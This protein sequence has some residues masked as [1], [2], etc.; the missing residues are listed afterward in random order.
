ME[1]STILL[2][3]L[4]FGEYIGLEHDI[5]GANYKDFEENVVVSLC[6]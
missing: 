4:D 1:H 2:K 5:H 6:G 3:I